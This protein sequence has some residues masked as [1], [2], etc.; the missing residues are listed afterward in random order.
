VAINVVMAAAPSTCRSCWASSGVDLFVLLAV[1]TT[2]FAAAVIING[3]VARQIGTNSAP[4]RW[5]GNRANATI[6]APRS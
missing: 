6:H 3:P 5:A 2:H 4:M 1:C